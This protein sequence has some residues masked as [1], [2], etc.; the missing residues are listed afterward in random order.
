MMFPFERPLP[1][2]GNTTQKVEDKHPYLSGVLTNYLSIQAIKAFA[3]Y[4]AAT[5]IGPK[6]TYTQQNKKY[7]T[8]QSL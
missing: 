6:I 2:H 7:K 1:T 3:L 4:R 5:G 8:L